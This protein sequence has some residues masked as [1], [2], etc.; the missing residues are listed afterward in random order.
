M[1]KTVSYRKTAIFAKIYHFMKK[2]LLFFTLLAF[3][4]ASTAQDL[5]FSKT[6]SSSVTYDFENDFT[7]GVWTTIDADGDGYDWFNGRQLGTEMGHNETDGFAISESYKWPNI[8]TPDNYLV[9][10]VFWATSESCISLWACS[11]DEMYPEEHFGIAVSTASNTNPDDFVTIAE[12]TIPNEWNKGMPRKTK[13]QSVWYEYTADLSAFAG[14]DIYVAVRHFNCTNQYK[15]DVDDI[16]I[17]AEPTTE[18]IS[19][20]C[21]ESIKIYPNPTEQFL[22]VEAEGIQRV[23]IVNAK[24][25]TIYDCIVDSNVKILD[26]SGLKSGLYIVR[27]STKKGVF[28]KKLI[29][30]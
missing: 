8:L 1:K 30:K 20:N 3:T 29:K 4:T 21:T 27:I 23:A 26:I 24:A 11:H 12:W 28:S 13:G 14:R 6:R 16:T 15:L 22:T 7:L 19:E 5:N 10:P 2:L 9:S 18:E 25:Q 17:V